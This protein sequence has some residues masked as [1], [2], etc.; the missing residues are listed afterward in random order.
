MTNLKCPICGEDF[1]RR[2]S[3]IKRGGKVLCCSTACMSKY[4]RGLDTLGDRVCKNC[5]KHFRTNPAYVRRRPETG[6]KFCSRSCFREYRVNHPSMFKD[7]K[8]YLVLR[9]IRYHRVKMQDYLNR[10]LESWEDVHHINGI[11]DDNRIENLEVLSHSE[12]SRRT[13]EAKRVIH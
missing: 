10:K 9:R 8:G 5:G 3:Y 7:S 1:Y 11:K 2:P 4:R 13:Q 6:G 12:H